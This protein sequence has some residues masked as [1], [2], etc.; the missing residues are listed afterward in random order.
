[1]A[2]PK[3]HRGARRPKRITRRERGTHQEAV[4]YSIAFGPTQLNRHWRRAIATMLRTERKPAHA[5]AVKLGDETLML[6]LAAALLNDLQTL[7]KRQQKA[8][9]AD[10]LAAY[11]QMLGLAHIEA[12]KASGHVLGAD[13][14]SKVLP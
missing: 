13:R 2:A 10:R 6:P 11:E 5:L 1:M 7:G 4:P 9:E 3:P 12:S 14:V 8:R